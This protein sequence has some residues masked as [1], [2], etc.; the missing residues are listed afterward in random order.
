MTPL[1]RLER[2]AELRQKADAGRERIRQREEARERDPTLMQDWLMAD[3]CEPQPSPP[4]SAAPPPGIVHRD[5]GGDATLPPSEP[6]SAASEGESDLDEYSCGIAEFV[7]TWC[8]HKLASRDARI[9]ILE[10]EIVALKRSIR[11]LAILKSE[12]A[13][14]KGMLGAT[15]QLLGQKR[16]HR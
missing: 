16:A 2:I 6:V 9:N 14:I 8:N 5:Y 4:V 11:E 12:N 10:E 3:A 7:V 1:E 15:L 13:E